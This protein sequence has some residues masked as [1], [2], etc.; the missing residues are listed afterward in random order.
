VVEVR[1]EVR[2]VARE[3]AAR[4]V[5]VR[6]KA[7]V[8]VERVAARVARVAARVVEGLALETRWSC[9]DRSSCRRRAGLSSCRPST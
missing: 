4:V 2:V 9:C 1:E 6:A 7:K 5:A 3:A 8:A